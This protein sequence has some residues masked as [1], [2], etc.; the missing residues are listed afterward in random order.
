MCGGSPSA[1]EGPSAVG[2]Y[3]ARRDISFHQ[4]FHSVLARL[5]SIIP[6]SSLIPL[7]SDVCHLVQRRIATGDAAETSGNDRN[8]SI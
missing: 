4:S 8:P 3:S 5:G 6:V 2:K 7:E 1:G